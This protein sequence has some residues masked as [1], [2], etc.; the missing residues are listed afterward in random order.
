MSYEMIHIEHSEPCSCGRGVVNHGI[1]ENDWFQR[2]KGSELDCWYCNKYKP[3][4]EKLSDNIIKEMK[5]WEDTLLKEFLDVFEVNWYSSSDLIEF[6]EKY[7]EENNKIDTNFE[8]LKIKFEAFK[9]EKEIKIEKEKRHNFYVDKVNE[10]YKELKSI[11]PNMN[12][13]EDIYSRNENEFFFW[14]NTHN[15]ELLNSFLKQYPKFSV[16]KYESE[17]SMM[18]KIAK[19]IDR[20]SYFNSSCLSV[21]DRKT[22]LFCEHLFFNFDI[23]FIFD[24]WEEMRNK[25]AVKEVSIKYKEIISIY[26]QLF[27]DS[28]VYNIVNGIEIVLNYYYEFKSINDTISKYY[29]KYIMLQKS[30]LNSEDYIEYQ[31]KRRLSYLEFLKEKYLN[32]EYDKE[33]EIIKYS[34]NS[35]LFELRNIEYKYIEVFDISVFFID[36]SIFP[37]LKINSMTLERHLEKIYNKNIKEVYINKEKEIGKL[38]TKQDLGFSLGGKNNSDNIFELDTT[39]MKYQ[40][41]L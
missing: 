30:I 15:G 14:Y 9:K 6:I 4:E 13:N 12:V 1:M 22:R 18:N 35:L 19:E 10:G 11:Y 16:S 33:V 26:R 17:L 38:L 40:S 29:D 23:S 8:E 24:A 36:S 41:I 21:L 25:K 20:L 27:K 3:L 37:K 7:F 2:K 34:N 5:K 39:E 28:H 32:L 31:K